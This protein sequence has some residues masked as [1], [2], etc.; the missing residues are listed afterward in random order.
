MLGCPGAR[1][2]LGTTTRSVMMM[3]PLGSWR[4]GLRRRQGCLMREMDPSSSK[5]ARSAATMM[6][7]EAV[8]F[9]G[10]LR[11]VTTEGGKQQA[12]AEHR[13]FQRLHALAVPC[14]MSRRFNFFKAR[15]RKPKA[16]RWQPREHGLGFEGPAAQGHVHAHKKKQREL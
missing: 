16:C 7:P 9:Q 15:K 4:T 13:P 12:L 2:P 14:R 3:Q 1:L 5:A 11:S 10:L 8:K 6:R